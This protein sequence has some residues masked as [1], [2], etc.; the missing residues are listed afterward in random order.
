MEEYFE[1]VRRKI[2]QQQDISISI[3]R[4][5]RI[6][7]LSRGSKISTIIKMHHNALPKDRAANWLMALWSRSGRIIC[8]TSNYKEIMK[9]NFKVGFKYH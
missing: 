2:K 7:E 8:T 4:T 9:S 3:N 6:L 5:F 1:R